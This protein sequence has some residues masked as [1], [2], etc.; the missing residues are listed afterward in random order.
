MSTSHCL[1]VLEEKTPKNTHTAA[2]LWF[3]VNFFQDSFRRA[4]N[5]GARKGD[6]RNS[7]QQTSSKNRE[8]GVALSLGGKVE[9]MKW[10]IY[11][12]N[13]TMKAWKMIFFFN[14][15]MF[16]FHL[17]VS[18]VSHLFFHVGVIPAELQPVGSS[19]IV[20]EALA[21]RLMSLKDETRECRTTQYILLQ[22]S[23]WKPGCCCCWVD[24]KMYM[25]IYLP[26]WYT[27]K[28]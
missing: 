15:V 7:Q 14:W 1:N 25:C 19:K 20:W 24:W 11:T 27:K 4:S 2:S 21:Q 9:K 6:L 22:W 12:W 8:G 13:T 16:K 5:P 23:I 10:E 3:Q 18:E 26:S 28:Y 17:Q